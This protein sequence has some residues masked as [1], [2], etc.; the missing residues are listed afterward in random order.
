MA[1]G[2]ASVLYGQ[3]SPGGVVNL[4]SKRPQDEAIHHVEY[5]VG[6]HGRQQFGIDLNDRLT[7]DSVEKVGPPKLPAHWLVK[8]PFLHAAT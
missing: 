3:M 6:S 2:P 7:D 4:T 5:Q 8:M 1:K